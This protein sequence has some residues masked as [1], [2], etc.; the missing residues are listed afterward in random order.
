VAGIGLPPNTA[1]LLSYQAGIERAQETGSSF[2]LSGHYADHLFAGNFDTPAYSALGL[3]ALAPTLAGEPFWHTL[4][5]LRIFD[6]QGSGSR[7]P[8]LR[9]IV[10]V[11][12]SGAD[13]MLPA[14]GATLSTPGFTKQAVDT[15][16]RRIGAA[17][18]DAKKTLEAADGRSG[19]NFIVQYAVERSLDMIPTQTAWINYAMPDRR[20]LA[21]PFTDREVIEFALGLTPRHRVGVGHGL[22][23]DKLIFRSAYHDEAKLKGIAQ[24]MQQGRLDAI[25]AVFVNQNFE[26]V[27]EL[28]A[29]DS[30]LCRLGVMDQDYAAKLSRKDAHRNGEHL[31]RLCAAEQWLR[32]LSDG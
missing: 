30:I 27:R 11:L 26:A 7:R 10:N 3:A 24:R 22:E 28:L 19:W 12:R 6:T 31:V 1:P 17:G 14:N 16:A 32:K 5:G 20:V 15:V 18:E 13:F 9:G 2:V 4:R 21:S 8:S 25:S 29:T 23:V